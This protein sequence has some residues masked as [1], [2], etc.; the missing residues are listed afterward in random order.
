MTQ[1]EPIELLNSREWRNVEFK[2]AG[3]ALP[4]NA[5]ETESAFAN[6]DSDQLFSVSGITK[7]GDLVSDQVDNEVERLV[8]D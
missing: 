5:Y 8:T 2:E 3:R 4:Y 7:K 6:T 1:D